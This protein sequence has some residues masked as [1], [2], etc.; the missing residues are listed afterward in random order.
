MKTYIDIETEKRLKELRDLESDIQK[1]Y[2][3][4]KRIYKLVG[5]DLEIKYGRA[6]IMFDKSMNED[7]GKKKLQMIDMM[8]RA[9]DALVEKIKANGYN[10]LEPY[11]RCYEFNKKVILV[12][13]YNDE[14]AI[15]MEN[16]KKET[17]VMFFSMEEMFRSIPS[18]FLE[19]KQFL[20]NKHGDVT[21]ERITYGKR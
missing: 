5:T 6:K 19:A 8:F 14:K 1:R 10:E 17:D 4:M 15:M 2:G 11:V 18:D 20:T 21:F 16:H 7:A 13:D 3:N 12:C 9:Y